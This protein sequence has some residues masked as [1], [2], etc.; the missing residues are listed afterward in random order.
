MGLS[1]RGVGL[2]APNSPFSIGQALS[3]G[4]ARIDPATA[5]ELFKRVEVGL[6]VRT[7]YQTAKLGRD[8]DTGEILLS[9]WP[10]VHGQAGPRAEP[11][12]R[13][14]RQV[15]PQR[16]RE[17]RPLSRLHGSRPADLPDPREP[18]TIKREVRGDRFAKW[19]PGV[20]KACTTSSNTAV[21]G[22]GPAI[23]P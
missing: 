7:E 20:R 18:A 21:T 14:G 1:A 4:G 5:C 3:Q 19:L 16:S 12:A 6:P 2:Y 11:P 17:A 9:P 13:R 22:S 8:R 23:P 10:D 15:A